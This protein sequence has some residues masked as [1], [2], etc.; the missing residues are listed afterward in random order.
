[1]PHSVLCICYSVLLYASTLVHV[2]AITLYWNE[3]HAEQF[4][5]V[6]YRRPKRKDTH[7]DKLPM[8]PL[9]A[10]C[11]IAWVN[12]LFCYAMLLLVD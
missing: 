4:L 12:P 3:L 9:Y 1:M 7:S 8:H 10:F 5:H 6:N 2:H 11:P